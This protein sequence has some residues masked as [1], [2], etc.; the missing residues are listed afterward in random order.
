MTISSARA[1]AISAAV[2]SVAIILLTVRMA[3]SFFPLLAALAWGI[4]RILCTLYASG[5]LVTRLFTAVQRAV[6]AAL[7]PIEGDSALTI[8]AG[9]CG[10]TKEVI[11]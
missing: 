11:V 5:V 7:R 9:T 1:S 2:L 4:F 8:S 3:L 10:D 6:L